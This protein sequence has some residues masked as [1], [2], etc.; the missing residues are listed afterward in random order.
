MADYR[1]KAQKTGPRKFPK[2]L[3]MISYRGS[4]LYN[5]SGSPLIAEKDVYYPPDYLADNATAVVLDP[6]SYEKYGLSTGNIFRKGR[7]A[8]LPIEEQFREESAVSR[9]LL[10]I[11][12]A[13]TQQGIFG[14]VSSYGLDKKDWIAYSAYSN[15]G[16]GSNWEFKNSPA[17]PHD[18]TQEYDYAKGSAIV[19]TS[20][21][22][23]FTNPGND[24]VE[25]AIRS[26]LGSGVGTNWT[27]YIQSL[28]AM[29]II[30][31]MV[32]NF[33]P[34][35]KQK[36]QIAYIDNNYPKNSQG[37]FNRLYWDRIWTDIDQSRV[38]S[39]GDI[40]IIPLGE[41]VNFGDSNSSLS[42]TIDIKDLYNS[43]VSTDEKDQDIYFGNLFFA[44]TRYTW[45]EP[46]KGHYQIKTN[47]EAE[48]WERYWGVDYVTDV[49][50]EVKNWEFTVYESEDEVPQFVKD[51]KLPYYLI[52][53]KTNAYNSLLFGESWPKS[54]SDS[55]IPQITK[56]LT[57]GNQIG[58]EISDYAAV[59]LQ[60][61]RAFR[62]QP[63]RISGF[64]YGVR[65][66]EE[67]AGPG[68]VIEFGV[69]NYSDGYFFRLKDGTDFSIVRRS[70]VPLGVSDVFI[71]AG[72]NEREAFVNQLTG[73][74]RYVDVSTAEEIESLEERVKE[75][76]W[77]KI[78]ETVIEQNQMNG[79]GLNNQGPSGYIYNPDTVT[80]YKIEFGWYGAIGARFYAYIPQ[81]KGE[82]RWVTLHTLVIENQIGQPCLQD[83]YFFFKYRV[84]VGDPS[85]LRLPQFIEKYGASYY[86]DGGDEGTV[87]MGSGSALNRVIRDVSDLDFTSTFPVSKW[88]TVL[89][90]KPKKEIIN[91]QGDEFYNKKEIFPISMSVIS[92]K[93]TEIKLI[94]QYGCQ[95]HA[96]TFQESYRCSLTESQRLRGKFFIKSYET[97]STVLDALNRTDLP[98]P[99]IT[100]TGPVAQGDYPTS[101]NNLGGNTFI[102]WE[103]L[104][105]G[106]LGSKIIADGLYCAYVNPTQEGAGSPNFIDDT[107][108]VLARLTR[109]NVFDGSPSNFGNWQ[110]G[111]LL[112][113]YPQ[114]IDAKLSTY[115]K[116]TTLISTVDIDTEEFYLFF[117]HRSGSAG[118]DSYEEATTSEN[119]EIVCNNTG[120]CDN[121]HIGDFQI[122]L[123]WPTSDTA[124]KPSTNYK[125]PKSLIHED[126]VGKSFAIL[127]PKDSNAQGADWTNA[128][129]ELTQNLSGDWYIKDKKVPNSDNFRYFE[130]LPIDPTHP[131]LS[132][133]VLIAN[134]QGDLGVNAQGL[135]VGERFWDALGGID[136]QLPGVPGQDGGRCRALYCTAGQIKENGKFITDG[137]TFLSKSSPWD[138]NLQKAGQ[139]IFAE[140]ITT[141]SQILTQVTGSQEIFQV[142]G[143]SIVEYRLPVTV[144]NG[145]PF[146]NETEIV[147]KYRAIAIYRTSLISKTASLISR[148]VVGATPF[149]IRFFIRMREGAEIGSV[150][151][152]KN[153]NNGIIQFPFTPHGSTLSISSTA[154]PDNHDGGVTD[155]SNA[156]AKHIGIFTH[157]DTLVRD[158]NYSFYDVSTST[159]SDE[160]K[161]CNSF[162]SKN[163]LDGTGFSGVG[164]YPLRFLKFKDSGDPVGSFYI[165][166]N[167]PT[168]IS[169]KEIFNIGG[170]SI[171]PTFW[172]NK[173]LFL[174]AR[175]IDL[176]SD[177]DGK[178]SVTLNYKEQ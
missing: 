166:A 93:D 145:T 101:F 84:Y 159:P 149:P 21:P 161:K 106:L 36:F 63:G 49:P 7:P 164:D 130:G 83:P 37:K 87:Q 147:I 95:E 15:Y 137:G 50:E 168:E 173:A 19:L 151:V 25:K 134:Q 9:S 132:A 136:A 162:L 74:I 100:Y 146:T 16:Q 43:N 54:Y 46:D 88:S 73:V 34:A 4:A 156:A 18:A 143:T 14:N 77:Y 104:D 38:G 72:Y 111:Q 116:D 85:A 28:V 1:I 62:Y 171:G 144:V 118:Y 2:E 94:N 176:A 30:E 5:E 6:E 121:K 109:Q 31:H 80:M 3:Q 17:G 41:F 112:T 68:S 108:T 105:G 154:T 155:T 167:T 172:S 165:S 124:A 103:G 174:I 110:D 55:R 10:G 33:T 70:T 51:H 23:P 71:E 117:T 69:E 102:G 135:E 114:E 13:E 142:P 24:P 75:G 22:V 131:S 175:D 158:Y 35:E 20:Y 48:V 65:V 99:T 8:A 56:K 60:S 89:G 120:G 44:T 39:T 125:Y 12:R 150:V 126:N 177:L 96:H 128:D 163:I 76:S 42:S 81:D 127:D 169:L 66:S 91:T 115:R 79:D 160:S 170:E 113:R 148:Q 67:G 122:G 59:T 40:P 153:T 52:S 107:T 97:D 78:Y 32:N 29:Y 140:D 11:N 27:R 47:S 45:I 138:S 133:N 64:T 119:F 98:T 86:I 26:E 141:L 92:N 58:R 157:P 178:I 61:I 152:G 123:I 90:V 82:S 139:N 57:E 129:V 53:D